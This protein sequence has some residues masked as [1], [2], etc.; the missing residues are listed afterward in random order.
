MGNVFKQLQGH[1]KAK[2]DTRNLP[3]RPG[4]FQIH[5]IGEAMGLRSSH[6]RGER[7]GAIPC[8][9][10]EVPEAQ[11]TA[12]LPLQPTVG[13]MVTLFWFVCFD[14]VIL[15]FSCFGFFVLFVVCFF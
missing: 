1:G 10:Q 14:L 2:G 13:A 4:S 11:G 6:R 7:A 12:D 8:Q 3:C 15:F 5:I 9:L